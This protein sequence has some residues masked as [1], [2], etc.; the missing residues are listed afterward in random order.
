MR[1]ASVRAVTCEIPL[2][3]P[4]VMGE[5]RFDAREYI[6]VIVETD[7]GVRGLGYGMTRNAP[8]AAIV[9]RN[10]GPLL[11]GQDPLM[12]EALWDR[13]Y[14][15]NLTIAGRGIFMR[16]LSAVDIALWDVK[17]QVA[18]QPIWR[19]LGGARKRAPLTVAGGYPGENVTTDALAREVDDYASRGFSIIKIAA[20]DLASDADRIR[21]AGAAIAGRA[22]LAYDAHWA[23][24]DLYTTVPVVTRWR[25]LGLAFIEDPF[26]PELV[27]LAPQFREDTGMRLALGEDAVGRW[28]FH[29][30]FRAIVPDVIRIDATTMGGISEAVKVCA[31]A[32]VHARPVIPHVFPEIHVHLAAALPTVTAVEMTVPESEI[33]LAYRLFSDWIRVEGGSIVAPTRPGLGVELDP[34]AV[35]RYR[36]DERVVT[37][38]VS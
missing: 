10:L 1:I 21:A 24:R 38:G 6:L 28:A 15:R 4:I 9:E 13:L 35:D 30:L 20:G 25:D 17:A 26:A 18:G 22:E 16:A 34:R 37:A 8:V 29:E 23:W 11:V 31:L 27:G 7:E 14:Y 5:L 33:D 36:V 19:L 2:S 3:R 32:S 12:T